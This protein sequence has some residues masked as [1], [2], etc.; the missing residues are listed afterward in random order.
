MKG[1]SKRIIRFAAVTAVVA[2][3]VVQPALATPKA[4]ERG[5]GFGSLIRKIIRILDTI[6]I[7]FP[8]G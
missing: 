3:I 1:V 7:R 6:D 5:S 2:A 4:P 8:P